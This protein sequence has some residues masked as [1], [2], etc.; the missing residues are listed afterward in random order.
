MRWNTLSTGV[1]VCVLGSGLAACGTEDAAP[2]DTSGGDSGGS[3]GAGGSGGTTNGGQGDA[4]AGKDGSAATGGK[5]G[6]G[7]ASGSGGGTGGGGATALGGS[8]GSGG[9]DAG[10][11]ALA[12]PL[13]VSSNPRY[14]QDANGRALVLAGSHTWNN[15]QDWGTAG[16]P[17]TFDFSAYTRFLVQHGHD[18]TL[19]WQIETP[20]FCGLPTT[21]SSP[22]DFT[23]SSFPWQRTGPGTASDGG[24]KFDLSKLDQTHFDRLRSRVMELYTA[25]IWVGVYLF[26]GE[27]LNVYRCAGDG[28]PLTGSNN[29]NA[30]D[31]GGGNG[32]MTMS[33]PNAITAIQDAMADKTI[34][35]LN[36]LPNVLW[37]VS[38]EAAAST[39]WWQAH[40]IA[41]VRA[42][43]AGKPHK[44]PIGLAAVTG[45]PDSTIYN[46][47]ADWVAPFAWLSPSSTCGTGTPACKVD[48]N[49]SDHSYFGMWNDSVQ[50]N[51]QYAWE[52]FARGNHVAFMD[53]YDVYYPRQNRNL[54]PSP[55][56]AICTGPDTRYDN[57]RD[58]LGY[59]VSYSRKLNLKAAQPSTTL[60]STTYC[61]GQTPA[62]GT[63][64]LVYAPDGG[65]FTVNLSQS[66]GRTMSYEWFNPATGQVVSTG[67]VPGGSS[68]QS[69]ITPASVT[70]DSVLYIVDS[71]GHA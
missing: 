4:S 2:Q 9:T 35:T 19:L 8:T 56:N 3:P 55:T 10:A 27:W 47:D 66:T 28:Y 70:A 1:V 40:M 59:I 21:A 32:S 62:V 29:I 25:G 37:I 53:P 38:E 49:D 48:I 16:A 18:F 26:T 51:R 11:T 24:L 20:K 39:M 68:N 69:F 36:D 43:E 44:H 6:S 5:T 60:C 61:L 30:I 17:Q 45:D 71:A 65:T 14:F 63:E 34:D 52:N 54:C 23:V 67:S 12:G 22:P 46:S 15:L 58:N 64:M 13:T 41:H 42:Y 57:F 33:S 31:D 50:R 7:G